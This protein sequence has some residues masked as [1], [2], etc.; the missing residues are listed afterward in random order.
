MDLNLGDLD[1]DNIGNWPLAAKASII[2]AVCLFIL[3][4]GYW[5]DVKPQLDRLTNE[6]GKELTLKQEFQAKQQQ[7][8]NLNDYKRQMVKMQRSFGDMLRQLP[9]Q[10]EVPGLVEDISKQGVSSGLEFRLIK[11]MPEVS[12]DFYVELPI[13]IEVVGT[14]H[15]LGEFVSAVAKLSRIVT[16]GNL[17]IRSED[18]K[19][20]EKAKKEGLPLSDELQLDIVATTYRY[21]A[22][23][24]IKTKKEP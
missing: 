10:S 16:F 6:E 19:A 12:H 24:E 22:N 23:Q 21:V 15:E 14:Y 9:S 11:P 3:F 1:I 7:A 5:F 13:K 8:A 2:T 4:L 18:V 17:T 20:R